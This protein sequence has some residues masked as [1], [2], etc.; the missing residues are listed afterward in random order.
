[1]NI[2]SVKPPIEERSVSSRDE[3]SN[4]L[5]TNILEFITICTVVGVLGYGSLRLIDSH[6]GEFAR[7]KELDRIERCQSLAE[8]GV[9]I[10]EMK[11]CSDIKGLSDRSK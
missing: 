8:R 5:L 10:S 2:N 7:Y 6:F 9:N 3:Q 11:I 1:M 4:D